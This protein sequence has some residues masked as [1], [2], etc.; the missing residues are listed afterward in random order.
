MLVFFVDYI[1]FCFVIH[2]MTQDEYDDAMENYSLA[3]SGVIV[4]AILTASVLFS[5]TV[6]RI[7]LVVKYL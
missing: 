3:Q 7:N 2:Y 4:L 1:I 6:R 5:I